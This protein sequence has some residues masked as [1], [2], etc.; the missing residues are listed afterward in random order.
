MVGS[1]RSDAAATLLRD[2]KSRRL[3]AKSPVLVLFVLFVVVVVVAVVAANEIVCGL[4][5]E[6]ALQKL[7]LLLL[8]PAMASSQNERVIVRR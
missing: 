5:Y 3:E 4:L 6:K 2:K 7:L 8:L 1:R